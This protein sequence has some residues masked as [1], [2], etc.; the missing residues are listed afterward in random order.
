MGS[1]KNISYDLVDS[2]GIVAGFMVPHPPMI[3]PDVGRGSEEK[4]RKT[5]E[6]YEAVAK[7][8]AEIKPDTIIITS[9]HATMYSNYFHISPGDRA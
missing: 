6:S 4:V 2:K 8:I 1:E 5:I 3:V 7:R 9:P